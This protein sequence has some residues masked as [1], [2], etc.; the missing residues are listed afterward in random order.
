[1]SN[2][3]VDILV[4][5]IG[6]PQCEL[7]GFDDEFAVRIA[8]AGH[9]GLR[10]G[11]AISLALVQSPQS[12]KAAEYGAASAAVW[13]PTFATSRNIYRIKV[14]S[15]VIDSTRRAVTC[16]VFNSGRKPSVPLMPTSWPT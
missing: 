16:C 5:I 6:W 3:R 1:M 14:R 13:L 2:R 9:V 7:C 11:C 12:A 8:A 10:R 15:P 4:A